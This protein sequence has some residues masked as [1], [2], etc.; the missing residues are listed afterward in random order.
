MIYGHFFQMIAAMFE[1][2]YAKHTIAKE[3]RKFPDFAVYRSALDTDLSVLAH[4][5]QIG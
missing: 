1:T 4:L 5:Y 2:M 3:R